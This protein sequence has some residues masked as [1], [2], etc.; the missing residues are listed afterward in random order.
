MRSIKPNKFQAYHLKPL[1][2]FS[3][4]FNNLCP[5]L[6]NPKYFTKAK[7]SVNPL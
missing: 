6:A 1:G 7:A 5:A 4:V 2:Q 3:L